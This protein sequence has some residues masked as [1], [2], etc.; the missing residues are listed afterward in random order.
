MDL[1]KK[2]SRGWNNATV[3]TAAVLRNWLAVHTI[4]LLQQAPYSHNLI[5]L[6]LYLIPIVKELL[7]GTNVATSSVVMA[8]DGVADYDCLSALVAAQA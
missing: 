8:A 5:P 1:F 4:P 7:A 3:H 2:S 6:H